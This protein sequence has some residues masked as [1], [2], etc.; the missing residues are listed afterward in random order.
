MIFATVGYSPFFAFSMDRLG[1]IT[2]W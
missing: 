1:S 2:C